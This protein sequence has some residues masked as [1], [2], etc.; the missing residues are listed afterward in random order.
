LKKGDD[1]LLASVVPKGSKKAARDAYRFM[2]NAAAKA[3]EQS[4][5]G[6]K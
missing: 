3:M 2:T 4:D 5:F 6:L 1:A